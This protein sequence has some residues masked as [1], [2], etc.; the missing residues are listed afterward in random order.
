MGCN[1][2]NTD[3]APKND[4][5]QDAVPHK[6]RCGDIALL[7]GRY[8]HATIVVEQ[9]CITAIEAG[10]NPLYTPYVCCAPTGS[11]GGAGVEGPQGEKG[12]PGENATISIGTVDT[13]APGS[14][15]TVTNV[16][17]TTNAILNF[18]LPAGDTG[19]SG[20]N[21]NGVSGNAGGIQLENGSITGLPAA[22][23]PVLYILPKTEPYDVSL[24][25]SEP[26]KETGAVTITLDLTRYQ[27]RIDGEHAERLEAVRSNLQSQID[28][29]RNDLASLTSR[30]TKLETS[31]PRA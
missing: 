16:G 6:C 30:V 26:D 25:A 20:A 17:T 3:C 15:A 1:C 24:E 13:L 5:A 12:E 14:Q 2:Q 11:G 29:L 8:E 22:W 31:L 28:S 21:P 4:C 10:E 19:K 7:D 18:G 9:G 23:P 27:E